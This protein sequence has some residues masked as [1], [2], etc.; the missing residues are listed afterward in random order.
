RP[1]WRCAPHC[2]QRSNWDTLEKG[3]WVSERRNIEA[4]SAT[5]ARRRQPPASSDIPLGTHRDDSEP[6]ETPRRSV[7][8]GATG[9]GE[10]AD[11]ERYRIRRLIGRGG[12]GEVHLAQDERVGRSV[13]LKV[14]RP[15]DTGF[16][17][18]KR[19]FL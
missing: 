7:D 3:A 9:L 17:D 16:A 19:R 13:A 10:L 2:Q 8:L 4:E 5:V 15:E 12:M 1:S 14:M 6:S 18:A 11:G